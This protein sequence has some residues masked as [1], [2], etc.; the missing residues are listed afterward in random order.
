MAKY[1]I[2]IRAEINILDIVMTTKPTVSLYSTWK[3]RRAG[4]R[5]YKLFLVN[6][7]A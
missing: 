2:V 3:W 4:V 5:L 7:A 1:K 6:L